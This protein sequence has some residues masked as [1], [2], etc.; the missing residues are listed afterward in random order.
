MFSLYK[1]KKC[2][3]LLN[4][5]TK[6]ILYVSYSVP[7]QMQIDIITVR[8]HIANVHEKTPCST[9]GAMLGQKKMGA[10]IQ[11]KHTDDANKKY[12]CKICPKG[13]ISN[14]M[15]QEHINV[16]TGNKPYM[17][18][19]CGTSFASF[20]THQMHERGHMGHKRRKNSE[21]NISKK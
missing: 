12:K 8:I 10:H 6:V 15:L 20:G 4:A 11:S 7:E 19:F 16:H 2:Y 21:A 1:Y 13:F 18:K 14:H 5:Q 3:L 17:C 9:C